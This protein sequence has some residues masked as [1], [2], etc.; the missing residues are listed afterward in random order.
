MTI[1]TT[2]L[3]LCRAVKG[4][5]ADD[6]MTLSAALS[7]YTLLSFAPLMVLIVWLGSSLEYGSQTAMLEQIEALAGENARKAA[8]AVL[9]SASV[10]P[11]AGSIAGAAGVFI[12]LIGATTVFAQL[13][14]SLNR[15][16][17]IKVKP[18]KAV[19][20]W[21]R[22][23]VLSI[24]LIAAIVFIL[25]VSLLVSS[26]LGAL[27]TRSGP[28]WDLLNQL[29]STAVL[30]GLFALL[31]RYLADVYLPW[32]RALWG[33]AIT[34][35]LFAVGKVGIGFYLAGGDVGGA[36]GAAGSLVVLLVWIYYSSAIFFFGAEIVQA[37]F[38]V[39]GE[40]M[41]PARH[42]ESANSS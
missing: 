32:H 11:S 20:Y 41:Q 26:L 28:V 30:A 6:A 3:L 23:R 19:W 17:G 18:G 37:W 38:N 33:G 35:I 24:G 36:Y 5:I 4:F 42:A 9:E 13:Q 27:L 15:I 7:F 40:T 1:K 10:R 12:S 25:I 16:W 14:A 8:Q 22:R 2:Y 21:L 34:G 31:F 29:I 39:R